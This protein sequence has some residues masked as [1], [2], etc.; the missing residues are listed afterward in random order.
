MKKELSYYTFEVGRGEWQPSNELEWN[1]FLHDFNSNKIIVFNVFN[2]GRFLNDLYKLKKETDFK[3]FSEEI[4]NL[5]IYYYWSKCEYE[6]IITSFPSYISKEELNRI[7]NEDVK[8]RTCVNLECEIKVDVYDQIMLNWDKFINYLWNNK[9]LI[10]KNK[11]A[12]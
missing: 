7:K 1:V 9:N 8:Y 11:G 12:N 10:K 4:R 6:T 5:I 3:K 2:H